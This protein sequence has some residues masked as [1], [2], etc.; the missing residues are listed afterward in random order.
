MVDIAD[1]AIK[2]VAGAIRAAV[3]G[4]SAAGAAF[5]T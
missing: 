1:E 3:T 2:V 4:T 5:T